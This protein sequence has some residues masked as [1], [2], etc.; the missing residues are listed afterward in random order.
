MRFGGAVRKGGGFAKGKRGGMMGVLFASS[1]LTRLE[2]K[3][4]GKRIRKKGKR[5]IRAAHR[6]LRKERGGTIGSEK[7]KKGSPPKKPSFP[8]IRGGG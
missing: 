4:K 1:S 8:L 7:E 6:H 5:S 3:K 2:G